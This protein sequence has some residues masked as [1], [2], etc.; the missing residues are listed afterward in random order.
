[1][2]YW[3]KYS[4]TNNHTDDFLVK[5]TNGLIWM[6]RSYWFILRYHIPDNL[7]NYRVSQKNATSYIF[8]DYRENRTPVFSI[9]TPLE[10]YISQLRTMKRSQWNYIPVGRYPSTGTGL[11]KNKIATRYLFSNCWKTVRPVCNVLTSL[12][13][14]IC[15][16]TNIENKNQTILLRGDISLKVTPPPKWNCTREVLVCLHVIFPYRWLEHP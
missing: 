16:L 5:V 10:S 1:M 4:N 8:L 11:F 9:N 14:Y 3:K 2:D 6:I 7:T 15:Q 13:S 12:K